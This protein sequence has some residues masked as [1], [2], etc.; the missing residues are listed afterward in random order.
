MRC[1]RACQTIRKKRILKTPL[2][3]IPSF[4]RARTA[5]GAFSPLSLGSFP[6]LWV[7]NFL[8][9]FTSSL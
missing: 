5:E 7:E 2:G 8:L 6:G 9:T 1:D 3:N 4:K